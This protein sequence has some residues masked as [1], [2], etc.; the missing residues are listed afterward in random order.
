MNLEKDKASLESLIK[1]EQS[2]IQQSQINIIKW[3]G[4]IDYIN[5]NLKEEADDRGANN[6]K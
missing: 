3:Q 1:R 6:E 2:Q 5:D 4:A